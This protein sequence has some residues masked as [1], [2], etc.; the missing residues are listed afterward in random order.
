[1]L[2]VISKEIFEKLITKTFN[3]NQNLLKK[4][5]INFLTLKLKMLGMVLK[6]NF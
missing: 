3:H 5:M 1:M 2:E 4:M 6:K